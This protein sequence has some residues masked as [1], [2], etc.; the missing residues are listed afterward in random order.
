M[1]IS[2]FTQILQRKGFPVNQASILLKQQQ[3]IQEHNYAAFLEKKKAE[4]VRHHSKENANY[5]D[6]IGNTNI[7]EWNNIPIMTKKDFQKPLSLRL[8]NGYSKNNVYINKTS[9][10]SGDPFFFAKDK[11]CH[12]LTWANIIDKFG[13]HG[14]DFNKS[15]Q[16]RFYGIP[17]DFKGNLKER[18]KDFFSNRYR[19]SVFDLSDAYLEKV[20]KKFRTKKF[21]YINGYT[22]SIV[23]FAKYLNKKNIV[24]KDVCPTLKCCIVT[25]EMLFEEDKTLLE[26]QFGVCVI[27]EYGASELDLIAFQN[28]NGEWQVNTETLFVE[29]VDEKGNVLPNGEEGRI[30]ITSLYNKAHPFIRYDIGD[31]GI[32]DEKSTAKN[33]FLKK[34][35][36][37]TND[38]AVLPSGKKAAGLTFY[39]ITKSII[40]DTG[41][42]KEFVIKQTK[43][44]TFEIEYVSERELNAS[45][46]IEI[47]KAMTNYLE[48]GLKI[49]FYRK[50]KLTRSPS[51]KLK[52]F[53]SLVK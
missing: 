50:E 11:F 48:K 52:Q 10:S 23:Q 41:N 31:M 40:E 6:F 12:A 38:I 45:Q 37:R 5:K 20:L 24:L 9:G 13:A 47:E 28:T 27:N 4:I 21:D 42:V 33:T 43:I 15:F 16:A 46:I 26:T 35:T 14:I 36:G 25:S 17:L 18:I 8:S 2:L 39:Y 49:H 51:G 1:K 19:F 29:I 34:L 3:Q 44:D 7:S 22:S 30:V 53:T 32:L